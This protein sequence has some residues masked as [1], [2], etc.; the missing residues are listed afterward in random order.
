MMLSETGAAYY[1]NSPSGSGAGELAT[2]QSW[3]QQCITNETLFNTYPKLKSISIFEWQKY[4]E[5]DIF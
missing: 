4:E 3:W 1:V 2:K 5:G